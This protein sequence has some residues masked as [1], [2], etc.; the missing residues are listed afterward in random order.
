MV[1]LAPNTL[2]ETNIGTAIE[3]FKKFLLVM[4]IVDSLKKRLIK[5]RIYS[6][7]RKF[8]TG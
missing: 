7:N 6:I 2:D 3:V 4:D 8:L 1:S 5:M